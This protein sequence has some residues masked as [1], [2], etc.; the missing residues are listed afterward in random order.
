MNEKVS[1][2]GIF[3][4]NV[5]NDAMMRE[6]LPKQVYQELKNTIERGEMLN[7]SIAD[8]IA[9]A[10]K[11]WA[12]ERGATH[13]THWFQPMTGITAEKHDSFLAPPS[14]GKVIMEFSGKELIKGESDASSF[15]SGACVRPLKQEAI[16]HGTLPH[17]HLL[18]GKLFVFLLHSVLMAVKRW[19]RKRRCFAL[20]RL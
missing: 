18:R 15:P 20:W 6:H 2:P 1:V 4:I 12:I 11:D 8:I 16:R 17:M 7:S 19:I 9:N 13:Y 10:M 5:F 3:G 14:N